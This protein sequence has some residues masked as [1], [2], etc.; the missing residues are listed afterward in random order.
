MIGGGIVKNGKAHVLEVSNRA[1]IQKLNA[2]DFST[3]SA[4]MDNHESSL[5]T[6]AHQL[7]NVVGL[8]DA[9]DT[10]QDSFSGFTGSVTVVGSV[11]FVGQS[12]TEKVLIFDNGVLTDVQ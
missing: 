11:D 6:N 2:T 3:L 12:V 4:R 7:T 1:N 8:V 9:L 10:K 5:N